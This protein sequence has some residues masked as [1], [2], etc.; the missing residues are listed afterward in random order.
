MSYYIAKKNVNVDAKG[1]T[2]NFNYHDFG[3][4]EAFQIKSYF[5]GFSSFNFRYHSTDHHVKGINLNLSPELSRDNTELTVTITSNMYDRGSNKLGSG[6]IT[7][8]VL[9][10]TEEEVKDGPGI[11]E[12]VALRGFKIEYSESDHHVAK[13]GASYDKNDIGKVFMEDRSGHKGSGNANGRKMRVSGEVLQALS[14]K[15]IHFI[16]RF[17]VGMCTSDHH[18]L[19]TG[20]TFKSNADVSYDLSDNSANYGKHGNLCY[21]DVDL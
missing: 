12:L 21:A 15:S 17:A 13:Y 14:K 4:K 1:A 10:S 18:V 9:V 3:V 6:D 2:V 11:I 7:V 16:N 19:S 5:V 8:S 20:V